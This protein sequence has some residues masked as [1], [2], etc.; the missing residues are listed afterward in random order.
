MRGAEL[1][2]RRLRRSGHLMRL[3]MRPVRPVGQPG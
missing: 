1:A 3:R 2:D